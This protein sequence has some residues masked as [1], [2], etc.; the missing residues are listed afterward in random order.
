MIVDSYATRKSL[1]AQLKI[2]QQLKEDVIGASGSKVNPQPGRIYPDGMRRV[3]YEPFIDGRYEEPV[4]GISD[5]MIEKLVRLKEFYLRPAYIVEFYSYASDFT[6]RGPD[7]NVFMTEDE[8]VQ[9]MD[10][11]SMEVSPFVVSAPLDK[12]VFDVRLPMYFVA[13][14]GSL[15]I[16][17]NVQGGSRLSA[18]NVL[19]TW[20]TQ[21]INL[22]FFAPEQQSASAGVIVMNV[23][24]LPRMDVT[25]HYILVEY[26]P[27]AYAAL[28]KLSTPI[29]YEGV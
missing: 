18:L 26:R 5:R 2:V 10:L 20:E 6:V 23:G 4:V 27:R 14:D 16:L 21:R 11:S 29:V 12:A 7:Q 9:Y 24:E 15:Y 25:Q 8:I 19:Q 17:Q 13:R 28:F 3:V 22:G 1:L